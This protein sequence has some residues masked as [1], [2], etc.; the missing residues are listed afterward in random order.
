MAT[1]HKRDRHLLQNYYIYAPTH[2][3]PH[4]EYISD[5]YQ[6]VESLQCVSI[7]QHKHHRGTT[8]ETTECLLLQSVLVPPNRRQIDRQPLQRQR[9]AAAACQPNEKKIEWKQKMHIMYKSMCAMWR[10]LNKAINTK[11][12]KNKKYNMF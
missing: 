8:T 6:S 9:V 3:K 2:S 11:Q 5:A 7:R 4:T 10:C 1:K 12:R